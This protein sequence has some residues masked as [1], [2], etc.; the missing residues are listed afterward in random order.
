MGENCGDTRTTA[1]AMIDL[2][3]DGW[4]VSH[5]FGM[6]G[7]GIN[8]LTEA[9]R[10]RKDDVR[11]VQ[12]RH[13]E[14][15]AFAA[16]GYAKFT[17]K[18]GVCIATTG[19]GAIHLLNGL[20]D[21]KLDHQPVLA[22]VGQQAATALGGHYQQEVDLISL[23]KD[24][25][26]EYVTMITHPEQLPMAVGRAVRIAAAERSVT[27]LILPN[28]VQEE[29]AQPRPPQEFKVVPGSVGFAWPRVL[30]P[31]AE[32]QRAATI[33]NEGERA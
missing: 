11:F 28:D 4:G 29:E 25:A 22:I 2:L 17:G 15:A 20:Y 30:P 12:T 23:F 27:C 18:L 31:D 7:D 10:V 5:I 26:S 21:A 19:P 9:L 33:L 1:Q 3:V 8:S 32:L 6:P 24:V 13:E 16:V 14:S